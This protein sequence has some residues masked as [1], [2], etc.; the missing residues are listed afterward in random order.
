MENIKKKKKQPNPYIRAVVWK[1]IDIITALL[2]LLVFT[3]I[4]YDVYFAKT[5]K[6]AF[7]N[8]VGL[9]ILTVFISLVIAKKTKLFSLLG[10]SGIFTLIFYLLRSIINDLV[11]ISF[12]AFLGLLLSKLITSPMKKKW[13]RI[14]DKTETADI[15]AEALD[16][17]VEKVIKRGGIV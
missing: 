1:V 7:Q 12:C 6:Y 2:P 9:S 11:V 10:I 13:E 4:Q 16:K 5:S 15:N 14:R 8:I 3:G 17:V